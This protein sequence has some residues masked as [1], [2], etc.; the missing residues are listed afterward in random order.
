M[1]PLFMWAGG[2]KKLLKKYE[3]HLPDNFESYHEPFFGGGAMFVWAYDKNPNANFYINDINEHIISIYRAVR[4][5]VETFCKYVDNL[6]GTYLDMPAPKQPGGETNK[7]LEK[8]YARPDLGRSRRDWKSILKEQRSRRHFYFAVRDEYA[9]RHEN[10]TQVNEA[11]MLYFLMKTGFNGVWQLNGNTNNRFGTPCGL[12]KHTDKVYDKDNVMEWH[13][14]LQKC[15]I[16]SGDYKQTLK[17]VGP[18]S[19][20][21]LDPP[22]RGGFADYGTE[23]DDNFQQEVVNYLNAAAARGAYCMLSNRDMGDGFFEDRKGDNQIEYFDVT[24]TVGRRKKVGVDENGKD[25][26]EAVKAKE[27]LMIGL[28]KES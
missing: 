4:D 12:M 5:D 21:F 28:D 25:I 3:P 24:Y 7:A 19:Y 18:G 6:Q 8:K 16:T 14:A 15:E 11:A 26:F 17:D 13:E 1:K 27:I 2:K 9:W 23:K 22:Y 20:I 10:L